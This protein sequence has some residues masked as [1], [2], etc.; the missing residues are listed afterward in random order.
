MRDSNSIELDGDVWRW[1][2]V[3]SFIGGEAVAPQAAFIVGLPAV[4]IMSLT[5]G[6]VNT[7][8]LGASS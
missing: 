2:N 3:L 5:N 8:I 1:L 7:L 4:L 6:T